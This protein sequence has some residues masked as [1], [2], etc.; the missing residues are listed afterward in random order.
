MS[1][2]PC[3]WTLSFGLDA[4]C[5]LYVRNEFV[6]FSA[7]VEKRTAPLCFQTKET[8]TEARSEKSKTSGHRE[9]RKQD[10]S[11]KLRSK[12]SLRVFVVPTVVRGSWLREWLLSMAV[13]H[14]LR[15]SM[16][17]SSSTLQVAG[18]GLSSFLLHTFVS[19]EWSSLNQGRV[20]MIGRGTGRGRCK[21]ERGGKEKKGRESRVG[22]RYTL[23]RGRGVE[24]RG[25]EAAE[26]KTG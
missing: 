17:C 14:V 20:E 21:E 25:C 7:E 4:V 8:E 2:G 9:E 1:R 22:R 11:W 23:N 26:E 5:V 19:R 18:C 13:V 15:S 3:R 16:S 10:E 24:L 6:L 12:W